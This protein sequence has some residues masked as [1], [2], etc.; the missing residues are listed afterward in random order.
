MAVRG[1]D[2]LREKANQG[3][4]SIRL[5]PIFDRIYRLSDEE[6]LELIEQLAFV[7]AYQHEATE[8]ARA[9]IEARVDAGVREADAFCARDFGE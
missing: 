7:Y 1:I 4:V 8:D 5:E 6:F 3:G 2:R 9:R